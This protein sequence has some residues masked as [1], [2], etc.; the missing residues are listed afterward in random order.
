MS[1]PKKNLQEGTRAKTSLI[2]SAMVRN[3][4]CPALSRIIKY[5]SS[6]SSKQKCVSNEKS[7]CP[8]CSLHFLSIYNLNYNHVFTTIMHHVT[9]KQR[10]TA[11]HEWL[12][13]VAANYNWNILQFAAMITMCPRQKTQATIYKKKCKV[14]LIL[15]LPM[16]EDIFRFLLQANM[17]S[18]P[19]TS[20]GTLFN[21]CFLDMQ[22]FTD[23]M[24][25]SL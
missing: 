19:R 12:V 6:P 17:S 21:Y 13:A 9:G 16:E 2:Y 8:G 10:A 23:R 24:T 14:L 7:V 15:V 25:W 1:D 22:I 4:K 18:I 3:A 5:L 11:Q 20:P